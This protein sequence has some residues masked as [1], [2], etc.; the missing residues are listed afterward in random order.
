M[1]RLKKTAF[2]NAGDRIRALPKDRRE[3]IEALA[4]EMAAELHLSEK[5]YCQML[6]TPVSGGVLD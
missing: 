2:G 1:A 4:G 5:S 3:R 6:V